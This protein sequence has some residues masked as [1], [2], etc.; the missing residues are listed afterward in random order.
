[1]GATKA[2]QRLRNRYTPIE[3]STKLLQPEVRD[4]IEIVGV[5]TRKPENT[6]SVLGWSP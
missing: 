6:S 5:D 1:L 4:L 2:L 3:M